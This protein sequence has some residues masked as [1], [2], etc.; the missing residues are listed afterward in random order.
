MQ[1]LRIVVSILTV[2]MALLT[3]LPLSKNQCWWVR[4][5]DF[6]RLQMATLSLLFVLTELWILPLG[7]PLATLIVLLSLACMIYQ[8]WWI[9]P[10][11]PLYPVQV[12]KTVPNG[13]PRLKIINC[14]VLM[15]NRQSADLLNIVKENC[16]DILVLLETDQW[17]EDQMAPLDADYPHSLR[18]PLDNLYG[19]HVYSRLPIFDGKIQY[20]V[21]D[22]I[23]SMHFRVELESGD[24]V[25]L[26][27]LHPMPPS[28]TED[29]ESTNRDGE[30]VAVGHT[31]ARASYPTIVTGDLN[32]VAWSRTTR[33][34]MKV[35]GLLD[36]RR[37]RGMFNTFHASLSF[38][39]WP[40][41]HVFHSKEFTL[42]DMQRLPPM[43]SDHFP[44][45]VELALTPQQGSSQESL[46]IGHEDVQEA[47]EK[48]E[49][50][51]VK[52]TD[53]HRAEV[54]SA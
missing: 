20:L 8:A 2:I 45:M 17:W 50:A 39:R 46:D 14:N 9:L 21:A 51:G 26:H 48:L 1:I 10:Y 44:I 38:L 34:F 42:I 5:W 31:A 4:V 16:P 19:M 41:D 33:L 29:D 23:P 6:P 49:S 52:S 25:I 35:S 27:C 12:K 40:L 24:Q 15:T 18:C 32:D 54:V 3:L 53:V 30:L 13:H 28:P 7:G 22:G 43:G 37:G 11:T 47:E 36:P